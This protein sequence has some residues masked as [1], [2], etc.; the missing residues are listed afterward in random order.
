M[1]G[2][3][4]FTCFCQ[5]PIL[6]CPL[7]GLLRSLCLPWQPRDRRAE[8]SWC[9]LL[10]D[11]RM[12]PVL[13]AAPIIHACAADGPADW[14]EVESTTGAVAGR[15]NPIYTHSVSSRR[16]ANR[17]C[18]FPASGSLR[19]H[20][21]AHG[22]SRAGTNGRTRHNCVLCTR[23]D[24]GESPCRP[25]RASGATTGGADH[26]PKRRQTTGSRCFRLGTTARLPIHSRLPPS[27]S[28]VVP[29]E[30]PRL[31]GVA[32]RKASIAC[33][34]LL[35]APFPDQGSFPPPALPGFISTTTLSATPR[36]RFRA[37]RHHRW[38]APPASHPKGFPVLH[39]TPLSH[40]PSPLP[41]R[42][43]WVPASFAFPNGGGLPRNSD[44]SASALPFSR[45]AQRSLHVTA[46][47]LAKS[48]RT[49]YTRSFDR[50]VT[51]T[52]V[53]I[54]TGWNDI[55][56]VGFAPTEVVH[57]CTAH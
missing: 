57:L 42:N 29:C 35:P 18:G 13:P 17:T 9:A 11:P 51:S 43:R 21:F 2:R 4:V 48:L 37:S 1:H 30:A 40:M 20:A 7:P 19:D 49:L 23:R 10:P 47:A 53:P 25:S 24:G 32:R 41:R 38:P 14:T 39:T 46:C 5:P 27:L 26:G 34:S 45:P 54:A 6:E 15:H 50:L 33:R 8:A 55:C 12:A 22:G 56:R 31:F 3:G 28:H 16:S 36:G 44:G 52:A